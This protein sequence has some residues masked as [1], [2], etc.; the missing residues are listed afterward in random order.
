MLRPTHSTRLPTPSVVD[1]PIAPSGTNIPTELGKLIVRDTELLRKLGWK[2]LVASRRKRGDFGDMRHLLHPAKNLLQHY[3]SNGVPVMFHGQPWNQEELNTAMKRGPHKSANEHVEF[4]CE[5]FADMIDK[6]QWLILPFEE[7]KDLPGLRLSPPGVIPQRNRRPRWIGDY[8]WSGVNQDTVPL[9]P[10]DAMQ[11]GRALDRILR[12]ILVA[13]PKYGPV[14]MIKTDL[15][16]GFY[17][18]NL[19]IED[20]PKLALV[21]PSVDGMPP[22]V[23]LPLCLPMGWKLSPPHFCA[24]TETIA[25]ITNA[26]IKQDSKEQKLHK[27]DERANL[28]EVKQ[29]TTTSLNIKRDPNLP[30]LD[31]PQ[32]MTEIFVDDFVLLAQGNEATLRKLRSTLFE[33]IDEVFRANDELDNTGS[34]KEPISLKKLDQGDCSWSS[35]KLVLGWLIDTIQLTLALPE[36]RVMRLKEILDSIPPTQKRTSVK[37]W[38]KV[39]GE[40]RS[41]SAAL[42]GARGLFS[43]MQLA[44]STESKHRINLSKGVHAALD[45]FRYLHQDIANRPTRLQEIVPLDPVVVKYHDA[46]GYAAGGVVIPTDT[47]VS[48]N[49]QNNPILWRATFPEDIRKRLVSTDN[50]KGDITNSDLELAS[51]VISNEAAAQNFD[52]RERTVHS[53]TDNTPTLFWLR[54]GSTTTA[55]APAH[56]LRAQA[57]HQ[58]FHRYVHRIDFVRGEHNDISDIPSRKTDWSDEKLLTYFN[59]H[60]PQPLP[61]KI[62]TPPPELLSC[63]AMCLRRKPFPR[64]SLLRQPPTSNGTGATGPSIAPQ[65]PSTHFSKSSKTKSSGS[66]SMLMH[67]ERVPYPIS[68]AP[69]ARNPLKMPYGRLAKRSS[70]WGPGTHA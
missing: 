61:W 41:M 16:D 23:A 24:V 7:V 12:E 28:I 10:M 30:S 9:A 19:R 46:S 26:R 37:K 31:K 8:T 47:A 43:Q 70:A 35:L 53:N 20:I 18:V 14:K 21:F 57:L 36:H 55:N 69:Y 62:W 48:R 68:G 34:R 29:G 60:Y 49:E 58:R 51:G 59:L 54:K 2:K 1:T 32:A 65:Y 39:L 15:S 38:H 22:L 66:V 44:L 64:E 13:N 6:D 17:R 67:T 50:P 56:L 33:V 63:M 4:L 5:D 25:D 3:K 52:I 45:D 11:Y 40:L 27:L 42:P